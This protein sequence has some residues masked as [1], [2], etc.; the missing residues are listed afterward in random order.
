[1]S[2][3]QD[4]FSEIAKKINSLETEVKTLKSKVVNAPLIAGKAQTRTIDT[5]EISVTGPWVLVVPETEPLMILTRSMAVQMAR[6][7]SYLLLP[8]VIPLP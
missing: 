5:G 2:S 1:M 7:C 3:I 8:M 4:V 6:S